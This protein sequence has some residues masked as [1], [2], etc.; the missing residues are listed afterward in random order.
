M[1]ALSKITVV[2]LMV[3]IAI[4]MILSA[5]I[6]PHFAQSYTKLNA[7]QPTNARSSIRTAP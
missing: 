7:R 4:L 1:R 3:A 2:D 6:L 5:I